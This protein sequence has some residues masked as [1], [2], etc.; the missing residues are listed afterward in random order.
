MFN[1]LADAVPMWRLVALL[2]GSSVLL[3]A[4][5]LADVL[6]RRT[7]SATRHLIWSL[8]MVGCLLLPVLTVVLPPVTVPGLTLPGAPVEQVVT[9]ATDL[10]QPASDPA[11]RSDALKPAAAE[12]A[13]P[14]EPAPGSPMGETPRSRSN[15]LR[16]GGVVLGVWLLGALLL[17]LKLVRGALV[18]RRTIAAARPLQDDAWRRTVREVARGAGLPPADVRLRQTDDRHAP[19]VAGLLKPVIL[20][21]RDA[22]SWGADL[23]SLVLNHEVAHLARRDGVTQ[24]LATLVVALYWPNPLV[25]LAARRMLCEREMACDDL[26]IQRGAD[27]TFYA[28]HLLEMARDL[29][30]PSLGLSTEVAMARRSEMSGRLMAILDSHR[31]RRTPGPAAWTLIAVLIGAATLSLG[32]AAPDFRTTEEPFAMATAGTSDG[33]SEVETRSWSLDQIREA[34]DEANRC[35]ERGVEDGSV[36]TMLEPYS[37]DMVLMAAQGA[38]GHGLGD[39]RKAFTAMVENYRRLDIRTAEIE[40]INDD[41]VYEMG[42][43][44]YDRGRSPRSLEGRYLSIWRLESGEWR[45]Y[46][47]ISNF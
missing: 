33:A 46:R 4:A 18:L 28:H 36:D 47:D 8:A 15:R 30:A 12:P 45:V 34:I 32:A 2:L 6:A 13:A 19:L 20:F 3:S 40:R 27:P 29:H 21:P 5:G 42:T 35:I 39:M 16:A 44:R 41:L 31:N 22:A 26:V 14:T 38:E 9:N 10:A 24:F 25:W 1:A 23:R 11:R 7:S 37:P 43:Y 17:I